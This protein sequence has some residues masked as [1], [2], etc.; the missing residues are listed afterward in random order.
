MD[1]FTTLNDD[2]NVFKNVNTILCL[3]MNLGE[4]VPLIG[5]FI[6]MI[7]YFRDRFKRYLKSNFKNSTL[8]LHKNST[9]LVESFL[10]SEI[11]STDDQD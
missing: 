1:A 6:V 4:N 2:T 7:L 11:M 9:F 8:K 5:M 10:E 3:C